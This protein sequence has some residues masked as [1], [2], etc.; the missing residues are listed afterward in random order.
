MTLLRP[1]SFVLPFAV[2]LFGLSCG[3]QSSAA[4]VEEEHGR[5]PTSVTVL[6]R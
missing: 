6:Q 1:V 2:L 3:P 5:E 4:F